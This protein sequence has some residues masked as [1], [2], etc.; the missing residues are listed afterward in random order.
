[1]QFSLTS[2]YIKLNSIVYF[3]SFF[4][5]HSLSES[6]CSIINKEKYESNKSER[7]QLFVDVCAIFL[8]VRTTWNVLFLFQLKFYILGV[9]KCWDIIA[10][11]AN[12]FIIFSRLFIFAFTFNFAVSENY[13][14]GIICPV[15]FQKI[16]HW[17]ISRIDHWITR[18]ILAITYS[19][20]DQWHASD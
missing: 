13:F 19:W 7:V 17:K 6:Y 4:C 3:F 2:S 20:S 1:M 5:M 8:L 11:F 18:S 14:C 15:L 16:K 10:R 12:L 9:H